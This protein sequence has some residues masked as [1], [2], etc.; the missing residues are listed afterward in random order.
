MN[1]IQ[2]EEIK[3][4]VS[5]G[6]NFSKKI[7]KIKSVINNIIKRIVDIVAGIVGTILIIPISLIVIISNLISKENG[8]LFFVQERVGK[9]GKLFKMYKF[10]TMVVDAEEK[11]Q[12]C[13]ESS[14]ET[15]EE[16]KKYKKLKNDPRI[17]KIGKFMRKT[18]LDEFPQF[19]N[20]LIGQMSL[21][22][23]RP[24]LP[25]EI[26][27]MGKYYEYIIKCKPGLTGLW[28]IAGRTNIN[29][30]TRLRLDYKYVKEKN[31]FYDLKILLNTFVITFTGKGA[32]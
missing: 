27:E 13:I 5:R 14:E 4:A 31:L 9:N 7:V 25:R 12:E 23:P 1:T 6:I 15:R 3:I 10:R 20:I 28:Q 29:F 11:L 17:T 32:M 24:Y 21:V 2:Q 19:I 30:K 18:S 26:E 16:Y 22:G 8:P